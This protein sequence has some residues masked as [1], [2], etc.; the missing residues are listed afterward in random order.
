M[1]CSDILSLKIAENW[2]LDICVGPALWLVVLVTAGFLVWRRCRSFASSWEPVEIVVPFVGGKVK[3]TPN[4][5][6]LRVAHQAWTE[7]TTRKA[8]LEFEEKHD[9]IVEVYDSWYDLFKEIRSLIKAIPAHKLKESKDAR[10]LVTILVR[11]LNEGL[12]PHLTRWQARFR[13]WYVLE[14]KR[15]SDEAPQEIQR[16]YPEYETLV[17]DLKRVTGQMVELAK[18]LQKISQG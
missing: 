11:V 15:T 2:G 13:R 1:N 17:E 10:Q 8:G 9:V 14:L 3:I 5:D 7:I 4:H 12:R 16:R 6:V 18:Q